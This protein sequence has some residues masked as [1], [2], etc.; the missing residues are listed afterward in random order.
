MTLQIPLLGILLATVAAMVVGTVWYSPALFGKSWMKMIG[1]DKEHM[2]EAMLKAVPMLVVV[3]LLTAYVLTIFIN[4]AH[5]FMPAQDWFTTAL[6]TSLW[7]WLGFGATTVLAHG[8][9]EP[10]ER[11]VMLIN[12]GNRLVTLVLMGAIIGAFLK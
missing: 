8:V 10:R 1:T 7:V 11:M 9:F 12:M 4:Y 5:A 3:A 2:D 6:V